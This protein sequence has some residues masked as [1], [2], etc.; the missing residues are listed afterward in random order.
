M[1]LLLIALLLSPIE[2]ETGI[3][4]GVHNTSGAAASFAINHYYLKDNL[5]IQGKLIAKQ[6]P[7]AHGSNFMFFNLGFT[8]HGVH[9]LMGIGRANHPEGDKQLTGHRQFN[10]GLFYDVGPFRVGWG[11]IS[12]CSG[13]CWGNKRLNLRPNSGRD[14]LTIKWVFKP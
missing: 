14:Y 9:W 8:G 1:N 12:N 10:L 4:W 2:L 7:D 13:I 3:G 11:H 5:Y 6:E